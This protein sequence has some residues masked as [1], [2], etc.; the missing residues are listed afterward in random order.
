VVPG[1]ILGIFT[2]ENQSLL[3]EQMA[4]LLGIDEAGYGPILGPLVVSAA[5]VELPDELL[6]KSLWDVLRK[7]VAK[8]R[9]G[10]AG[11]VVI[12]DSKKLHT[13]R[14][15]GCLQRGVLAALAAAKMNPVKNLGDLLTRLDSN[16]VSNLGGYPWYDGAKDYKLRYDL[17]D[18]ATAG[19]GMVQEMAERGMRIVGLWSRVLPVG[20]FNE[21][22]EAVDNKASV[23]FS[24][25][26]QLVQQAYQRFGRQNLQIVIDK[27]S[28]RSHYR[29]PLQR[30]FGDLA[31]KVIQEE[32]TTSSYQ[33]SGSGRSMKIHFLQKGEQRQWPIA[34]ASMTS[35]YVRE[36]FMEMLNAYFQQRFTEVKP[37]AG[38]YKD[39]KR[40]LA[41]L[42]GKVD[43]KAAP[44][45]LLVRNR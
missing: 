42:E 1:I 43:E 39:G 16:V 4:I 38:Y 33:L 24:L 17:D 8:T 15:Y 19:A 26:C 20:R 37:T 18:V 35:K 45:R 7:S 28:G 29:K 23:L 36:L 22:V 30:M 27:Q 40:F 10:A 34:L 44:N 13:G 5:V 3:G 12:N 41:E 14:D 2:L 25:I 9:A 32:D 21:M 11:R 31:M 6:G